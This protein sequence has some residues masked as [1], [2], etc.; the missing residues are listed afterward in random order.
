MGQVARPFWRDCD[1][2][3]RLYSRRYGR[4]IRC[5]EISG[6]PVALHPDRFHIGTNAR[7]LSNLPSFKKTMALRRRKTGNN[8]SEVAR[9]MLFTS[10]LWAFIGMGFLM[11][12]HRAGLPVFFL[13]WAIA[14]LDLF[15]L[16]RAIAWIMLAMGEDP[17]KLRLASIR[18]FIWWSLKIA[19]VGIL[20]AALWFNRT[21][22]PVAIFSGLA[23]LF[24]VPVGG[25]FWWNKR[26]LHHA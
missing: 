15:L 16:A 10:V 20:I 4:G 7:F 25:G 13:F 21:R 19:C 24:V 12:E 17:K 2:A 11:F 26:A 18:A 3:L 6:L 1:L 14:T 5:L 22:D 8:E 9:L 23:T